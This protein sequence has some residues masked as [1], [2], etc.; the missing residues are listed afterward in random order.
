[1]RKINPKGNFSCILTEWWGKCIRNG[2]KLQ[3][4]LF[5]KE[6]RLGSMTK[7][8]KLGLGFGS[9]SSVRARKNWARSTFMW[10]VVW[11][12]VDT[13]LTIGNE[14]LQARP[15]WC[16]S[17]SMENG[18]W[19]VIWL[20]DSQHLN[21]WQKMGFYDKSRAGVKGLEKVKIGWV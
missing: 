6:A 11:Q 21:V 17:T 4:W 5:L 16:C 7:N 1:M 12:L 3:C 18:K 14:V 10:Q 20:W 8:T 2:Q 13:N 15:Q 19:P 9:S